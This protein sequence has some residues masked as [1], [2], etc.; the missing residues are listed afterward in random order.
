MLVRR[1]DV[2]AVSPNFPT[3]TVS[4]MP[5]AAAISAAVM[6]RSGRWWAVATSPTRLIGSRF[7]SRECGR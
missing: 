4:G 6:T 3:T 2:L 1:G 7:R 5:L